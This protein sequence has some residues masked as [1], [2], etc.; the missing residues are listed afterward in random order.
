[1]LE[2]LNWARD[3][4]RWPHRE[5]SQFVE[6]G[7][8]RWHVQRFGQA[9]AADRTV[10]L[11]HGTG[12]ATHSW[13]VLAPLLARRFKVVAMDLPGH[14]FTSMPDTGRM[15]LPGMSAAVADLLDAL[16]ERPVLAV[17]HSAGAAIA[18]RM[19]LDRRIDPRAIV[20]INGALLPLPGLAGR[21]YAP[22]ARLLALNPLVPRLF[23]WRAAEK[24]V[25]LRLIE[26]TGSKIDAEGIA[27]YG[28]LVGSPGHA[29]AALAM[30]AAWDLNR[31]AADL[32]AMKTP[33][34][35]LAGERDRTVSPEQAQTLAAR[36]PNA[37][38]CVL[39]ELGHLAHEEQPGTVLA[40]ME[41]ALVA[42][43]T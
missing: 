1:M 40:A 24:R 37:H 34:W 10:V 2:R 29:A 6:A 9:N 23:A 18:A 28:Q 22:M 16:G 13:R 35:L 26:G 32:P 3:G 20:S 36:M 12:A 25:L 19:V 4:A 21:V 11:L 15:S 17:G 43:T 33:L 8:V 31:L 30:M 5:A 27:L 38:L 14:G 41:P 39:P 7:G 42:S